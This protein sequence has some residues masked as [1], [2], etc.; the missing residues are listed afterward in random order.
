MTSRFGFLPSVMGAVLLLCAGPAVA[1]AATLTDAQLLSQFNVV[2]FGNFSSSSDVEGAAAIG[3]NMTGGATFNINPGPEQSAAGAGSAAAAGYGAVNVFGSIA[4]GT[5]NVNNGGSVVYGGANAGSFNMN[6]GGTVSSS[7]A[8]NG[9]T[10]ASQFQSPLTQLSQSLAALTANSSMP[11]P[12]TTPGYPNNVAITASAN[13]PGGISVFN[14]SSTDLSSLSSFTLDT[15][16]ATTVI[17]NVDVA[18]VCSSPSV[19]SNPL[20]LSANFENESSVAS[21]IIWNFYNAT[22]LDFTT[23]WGGTILAPDADVTN[24][25]QLNGT[26]VADNYDGDGEVHDVPFAGTLP[27]T[28]TTTGSAPVPEPPSMLVLLAGLFG[29]GIIRRRRVAR[30]AV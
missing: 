12:A 2:V 7:A 13:L 9:A 14:I 6:G 20:T 3:G 11:N 27:A 16:G 24:S 23:A 17:F 18:Q 19:C 28:T 26:L 25:A 4:A 21:D 8:L 30:V 29:L 10:F 5:Y 22:S 1:R 15:N